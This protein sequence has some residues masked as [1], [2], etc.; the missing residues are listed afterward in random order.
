MTRFGLTI[1]LLLS[2]CGQ[3]AGEAPQSEGP[4][5]TDVAAKG[6]AT[7]D[8]GRALPDYLPDYPGS[9]R[10]EVP[11]LGAP[12]TDS[13]SGNAIAMETDASPAQVAQYYRARFAEAGVR[14]W[15]DTANEQGGL[16]SVGREGERGAMITISNV[17]GKTR[18]GVVQGPP[19]P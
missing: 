12:G 2:A 5:P 15:R 7:K 10:V 8:G 18:I 4:S 19:G 6:G 13:R 17:A 16:I 9:T 11:N 3:P 1:V 14:V